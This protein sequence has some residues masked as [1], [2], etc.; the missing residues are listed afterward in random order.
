MFDWDNMRPV[1]SAEQLFKEAQEA[2]Q[3]RK[4]I[5]KILGRPEPSP[6]TND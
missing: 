6:K 4:V 2:K 1:K 3:R 5:I